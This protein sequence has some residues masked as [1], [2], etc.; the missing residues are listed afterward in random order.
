MAGEARISLAAS[1]DYP[2]VLAYMVEAQHLGHIIADFDSPPE[3]VTRAQEARAE[4]D[5]AYPEFKSK[6]DEALEKAI[7]GHR[8]DS[9]AVLAYEGL[10]KA[11]MANLSWQERR[12]TLNHLHSVLRFVD[13]DIL[14]QINEARRRVTFMHARDAGYPTE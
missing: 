14:R 10:L 9:P 1:S 4:L 8:T 6:A 2:D 13:P 3:L 7:A 12:R 5:G 11:T